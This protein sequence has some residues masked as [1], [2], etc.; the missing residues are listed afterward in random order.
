MTLHST[1]CH[2]S[3]M[4][5]VIQSLDTLNLSELDELLPIL[6]KKPAYRER[7]SGVCRDIVNFGYL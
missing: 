4:P 1:T 2:S 6:I 3:D 7:M 5:D